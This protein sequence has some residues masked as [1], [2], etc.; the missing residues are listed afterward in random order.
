VTGSTTAEVATFD[1]LDADRITRPESLG[2]ALRR[3]I[4]GR[5][6]IDPFGL[7]PQIGDLVATSL[8][9][10][11]PV[12]VSGGEHVPASGPA[13]IVANRGF[14]VFEPAALAIAVQR[15]TGRRLRVVGAPSVPFLGALT[16]RL[17]AIGSSEPDVAVALRAGHLVGVPLSPTW[18]RTS[19]GMPPQALMPALTHA[20]IIPAAVTGRGPFG[21]SFAGW[22][23][24]FGSLV[25]LDDPYDPDDPL[26][27][28]R[29]ADAMRASV[30]ALLNDA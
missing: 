5:Y 3:R 6:P 29:F 23:V 10:A 28:A 7:D 1:V 21:T 24:R 2:R 4:A 12:H 30:R 25:T 14:G 17:G 26:A 15:V 20:P 11:I 18:L 8:Q 27:A 16:R 22:S 9:V 13:A 19:A